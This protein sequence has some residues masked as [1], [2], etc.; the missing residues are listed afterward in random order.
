MDF[1]IVVMNVVNDT[2]DKVPVLSRK[3]K[4]NFRYGVFKG[5]MINLK[6]FFKLLLTNLN[7]KLIKLFKIRNIFLDNLNHKMNLIY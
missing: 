3:C 6:L 4:P 5:V 2:W 1:G 7:Y